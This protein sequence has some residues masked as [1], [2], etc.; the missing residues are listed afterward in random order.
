MSPPSSR[1]SRAARCSGRRLRIRP[2]V[3]ACLAILVGLG[4]APISVAA[5]ARDDRP[6][7]AVR[8]H[9]RSNPDHAAAAWI[10]SDIK[11]QVLRDSG[12]V[13]TV[14]VLDDWDTLSQRVKERSSC[15]PGSHR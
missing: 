6:R 9:G 3:W 14:S 2:R 10:R 13:G 5:H 1:N 8:A 7:S 15:I 11:T 12:L 4:V